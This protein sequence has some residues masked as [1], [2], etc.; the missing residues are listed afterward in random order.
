MH[1]SALRST[2]PVLAA[3]SAFRP[4]HP[5]PVR[6]QRRASNS[7]HHGEASSARTSIVDQLIAAAVVSAMTRQSA[8]SAAHSALLIFGR[9]SNRSHRL[10]R[11]TRGSRVILKDEVSTPFFFWWHQTNAAM[12][13]HIEQSPA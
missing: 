7:Y 3:G 10:S 12:A 11:P 5:R 6:T 8:V 9:G 2:L 1:R 4:R 13:G